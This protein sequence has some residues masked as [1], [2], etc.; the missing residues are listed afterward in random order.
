MKV[1]V[2]KEVAKEKARMIK[3]Q[4]RWSY[5]NR[6]GRRKVQQQSWRVS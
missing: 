5:S 4:R 1:K 3:Q 2:G 6:T